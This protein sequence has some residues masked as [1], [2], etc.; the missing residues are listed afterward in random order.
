MTPNRSASVVRGKAPGLLL[1]WVGVLAFSGTLPATLV[2]DPVFGPV[3]VGMGRSVIAGLLA[4]AVLKSRGEPLVVPTLVPRLLI[5]VAGV[6]IGFPLLTAIALQDVSSAH[7]A[8]VAGLL[9]AATAGMA[10]ARAGERPGRSYWFALGTGLAAVLAFAAAAGAGLPRLP[11]VLVLAAVGLA[12]LG[13]AEGGAMSRTYGGWRV[14]CWALV[15][16]MPLLVPATALAIAL[17]PATHVT[18]AAV[19]GLAYVSCISMFLGFFAWY[20]GLARG[21][22]ARI[23]RLQLAQPVL[24]LAWSALLLGER[25]DVYTALAALVVLAS[26]AVGR[27]ACVERSAPEPS[28]A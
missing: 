16:A 26:V 15:L 18:P 14:I 11:D 20:E 4:V 28:V 3:T 9:P 24:T 2:A 13:Y 19:A 7:A 17:H 23:G 12:G 8:V 10:V 6:V 5:V 21:G 22:V 25:I 27:K 1:G